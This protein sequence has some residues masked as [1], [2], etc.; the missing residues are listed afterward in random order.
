MRKLLL[1]LFLFSPAIAPVLAANPAPSESEAHRL[2]ITYY[3]LPG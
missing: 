1:A 2:T 3:Y